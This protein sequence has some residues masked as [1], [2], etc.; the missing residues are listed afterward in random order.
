MWKI[1]S[2]SILVSL[3]GL[4]SGM[5]FRIKKIRIPF[6][7]LLLISLCPFILVYLVM[8][9]TSVFVQ[10]MNQQVSKAVGFVLFMTLS[11]LSLR[12]AMM[13]KDKNPSLITL[14]NQPQRSDLNHD[15]KISIREALLLGV[16][17]SLDN[18]IL[19]FSFT[20][21]QINPLFISLLFGIIN[22]FLVK[23]GNTLPFLSYLEKWEKGSEYLPS[24]LFLILALSRLV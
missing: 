9:C 11:C 1:L 15:Q 23:A 3:D 4:F 16:A 8:T 2:L 6:Y 22:F 10:Q 19:G 13:K 5:S 18:A 17:L 20:L 14:I 12:D 21:S 7:R 24:L